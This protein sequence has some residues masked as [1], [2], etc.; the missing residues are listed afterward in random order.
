VSG[1]ARVQLIIERLHAAGELQ[2]LWLRL[3]G[4][5]HTHNEFFAPKHLNKLIEKPRDAFN[6]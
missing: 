1:G 4:I 3:W 6:K 5:R 2:D